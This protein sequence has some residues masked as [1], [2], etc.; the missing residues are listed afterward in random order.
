MWK[1][2]EIVRIIEDNS[3]LHISVL[4]MSSLR[5][6]NLSGLEYFAVTENFGCSESFTG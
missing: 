3:N 2:M 5:R 6:R 4:L 1:P